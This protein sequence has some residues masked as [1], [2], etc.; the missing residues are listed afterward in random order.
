ME[1]S[2]DT[3]T[4][5][6]ATHLLKDIGSVHYD[7]KMSNKHRATGSDPDPMAEELRQMSIESKNKDIPHTEPSRRW[8][9]ID[10]SRVVGVD[11]PWDGL[12]Y[13]GTRES[14]G[15]QRNEQHQA[16]PGSQ[17]SSSLDVERGQQRVTGGG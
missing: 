14:S 15:Q 13:M 9:S 11:R 3:R 6:H 10:R 4:R 8:V 5:R 17:K 12:A 2:R 7:Q 16:R 1:R